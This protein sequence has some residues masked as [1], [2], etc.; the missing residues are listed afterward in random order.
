MESKTGFLSNRELESLTSDERQKYFNELKG[1]C[2]DQQIPKSGQHF[3]QKIISAVSPMIRNYEFEIQGKDNIPAK[4]NVLFVANHSNA[5]D[6]FTTQETFNSV[7]VQITFLASNEDIS[8]LIIS[9]FQACNGVLI[10]RN[11]KHSINNGIFQFASSI[12]N[13]MSG[14]IFSESTWNLHPYRPV[15]PIKVGAAHIAAV[16]EIPIVPV[17][18]EYVEVPFLCT[19]EKEIYSKCIVK[20][21]ESLYIS[22][23]ENLILQTEKIQS[24]LEKIRMGLW[25]ELGTARM[26][27]SDVKPDLYGNHT[28]LRKFGTAAEYDS[29]REIKFVL[30]PNGLPVEN[31]FCFDNNKNLIPGIIEKKE[32]EKYVVR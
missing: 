11:D 19:K 28:W 6:F 8:H 2:I 4:G 26:S 21:G 9:V 24:A 16:L 15:L 13:G 30:S 27:L 3:L 31:E 14:V 5:H 22:R 29:R 32:K 10:N 17:I 20:F 23:T 25:E 18:F 12:A 1:H 7:G